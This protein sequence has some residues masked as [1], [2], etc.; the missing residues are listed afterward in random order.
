M[1]GQDIMSGTLVVLLF[2]VIIF[3]TSGYFIV[4]RWNNI[5]ITQ[6]VRTIKENK[7]RKVNATI[8]YAVGMILFSFAI[9]LT[10][11]VGF[12]VWNYVF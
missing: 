2:V 1:K 7:R 10:I 4:E 8:A 3:A 9:G 5:P 6:Q 11:Y 12:Q